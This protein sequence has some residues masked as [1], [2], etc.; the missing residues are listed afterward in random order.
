MSCNL[1][2]FFSLVRSLSRIKSNI[3]LIYIGSCPLHL[4]HNSFKIGINCTN[5]SMEEFL[6]SLVHW[7]RHSPSRREDYHKISK[8][9]GKFIPHFTT[10]RW[11]EIEST[12]ERVIDQWTN[13]EEYFLRYLPKNIKSSI[14]KHRYSSIKTFLQT[15]INL[16]YLNFLVFL[17]H[18]IFGQILLWFQSTQ[19]LI[20][21]LYD[22]CEQ[23]IRRLFSHFIHEDLIKNKTLNEL[24]NIQFYL[25]EN[26]KSNSSK[27]RFCLLFT[28]VSSPSKA[29]GR[30]SRVE[31]YEFG[32]KKHRPAAL[33]S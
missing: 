11:L 8:N 23:L 12:L 16:I 15:P 26:Q 5:W 21:L 30:L 25:Q 28:N 2:D 13:L 10:T 19:P 31:S 4:I 32:S 27:E 3:G 9:N 20:H 1:S 33:Y 6:H 24:I 29:G 17:S 22:E 7:F 14:N 18:N